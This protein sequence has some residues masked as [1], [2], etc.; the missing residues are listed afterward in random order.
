MVAS[1]SALASLHQ[2]QHGLARPI[3]D[4][5]LLVAE[6]VWRLA[7]VRART[8]R[9]ERAGEQIRS[10]RRR[11]P[12]A[13]YVPALW[14]AARRLRRRG[15]RRRGSAARGRAGTGEVMPMP[16]KTLPSSDNMAD[17]T[18]LMIATRIE[19]ARRGRGEDRIAIVEAPG[20]KL[21][22][23]A[24]GAGGVAGGARAAE[25]ICGAMI[26]DTSDWPM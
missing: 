10:A 24:D 26:G 5:G 12:V 1:S 25:S 22:V 8:R 18:R 16:T 6:V 19:E 13:S 17:T 9:Q 3:L 14:Q 21:V 20:R 23:V 7:T 11:A 15:D 2:F 4:D